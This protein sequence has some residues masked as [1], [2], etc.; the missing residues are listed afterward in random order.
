VRHHTSVDAPQ[1]RSGPVGTALTCGMYA[2]S[3]KPAVDCA[4][5]DNKTCRLAG[6]LT[7]ATGLEP[8]TSGVTGRSWRFRAERGSAGVPVVSGP[9]G[10]AVAGIRGYLRELPAASCGISA[11]CSVVRIDNQRELAVRSACVDA[12]G[13]PAAPSP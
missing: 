9:F 8:A 12:N 3:R 10:R 7:G 5:G 13:G 1:E 2:G 6:S 4:R 11:G